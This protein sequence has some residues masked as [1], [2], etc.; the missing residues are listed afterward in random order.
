[1]HLQWSNCL[2]LSDAG[3]EYTG[4]GSGRSLSN[5][6]LLLRCKGTTSKD[7]A[8]RL[9]LGAV[10]VKGKW[11]L[12]LSGSDN[13]VDVLQDSKKAKMAVE[14]IQQVGGPVSP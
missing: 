7:A 4:G 3:V 5:T 11:Q 13:M 10:E 12:S 8:S 9:I 1:M 14:V 2:A 6:D